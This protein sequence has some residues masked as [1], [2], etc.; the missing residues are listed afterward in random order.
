MT[1]NYNSIRFGPIY[2][3][4]EK[5]VRHIFDF[6]N[7]KIRKYEFKN[8]LSLKSSAERQPAYFTEADL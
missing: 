7:D 1:V 6:V 5:E 2:A 3:K 8:Q 4:D